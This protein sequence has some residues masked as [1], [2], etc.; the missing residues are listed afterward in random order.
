[1]ATIGSQL[2]LTDSMTSVLRRIN[3]A[4]LVCLDSFESMQGASGN[5]IDTSAIDAARSSLIG[6]NA[7]LDAIADGQNQVNSALG[8]GA[9]AADNLLGK[10]KGIVGAYLGIQGAKKAFELSDKMVSTTARLEMV[11]D[12]KNSSDSIDELESKIFASAERAR[13]SYQTTADAVAKF[14]L[15]A[16]DAFSST[17]EIIAFSEQLNKS[18][19]VAGTEAS[20]IDS[21]MLQLTQAMGSGVLRG[22]EFNSILEQAPNI[23]Q[24][25]ADYMEVPKG[26]LKDLAAEGKITADIVKNALLNPEAV[27]KLNSQFESMPMTFAQVWQSFQNEALMAFQPVLLGLNDLLNSEK[28]QT[29]IGIATGALSSIAEF[30][31]WAFEVI[32][33]IAVFIADNWSV[34]E[35][36][37]WGVVTA[38]AAYALITKILDAVHKGFFKTL[39]TNPITWIAVLI[40]VAVAAIYKWIQS[41]GGLQRA[42][43][44]CKAALM[45]AWN[46]M[47]VA[48]Y[49]VVFG[50][51]WGINR[52]LDFIDILKS[53]W[54]Y[55]GIAIA[56]FVGDM[57]VSVLTVLQN[58][59]NG[60]I[61]IINGFINALNMIPFVNIQTIGHVTFA[62]EAAAENEAA[63][64][65]REAEAKSFEADLAAAKASR[66]ASED[67][68]KANLDNAVNDLTN[69]TE[70]LATLYAASA[71]AAGEGEAENAAK[72]A[73]N[74][75]IFSSIDENTG[76]AAASLKDVTED[77][78]YLRDS[79]EREAIN[80]F[81]TAEVKID[82]TGMTNRIDSSMDL[83]GV[84]ST[85]T[86]GFA[87]ALETTAEGV[88]A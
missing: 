14:G 25:I 40:G 67:A 49:A 83:D 3:S 51:T 20:G 37:V 24:A 44:I 19:A 22:E 43:E 75:D 23:I 45:V 34:I 70:E 88:H 30:A 5:S 11:I 39:L 78:K 29:F 54:F 81:T 57:K 2:Q 31:L 9:G 85:L 28:F 18:F 41:V 6:V 74:E 73:A 71:A 62:T 16:G 27:E 65:A 84:L 68:A 50:I 72:D 61:D 26:A 79:A 52:V 55:A 32:A 48:W 53:A 60:A 66:Q 33:N 4:L 13:G 82:M 64:Q 42:W 8:Q 87:E 76:S 56:N 38:F 10:L 80:R 35:P 59:I 77:L 12:N 47:S 86:E 63:K 15:M 17:N 21:A 1:M 36:I 58:M 7:Q 46:A 69:S